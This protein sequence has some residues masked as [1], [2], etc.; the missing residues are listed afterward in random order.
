MC[1]EFHAVGPA[2]EMNCQQNVCM[3]VVQRSPDAVQIAVDC[4]NRLDRVRP[5]IAALYR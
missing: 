2:T 5:D 4:Q 3:F 1:K